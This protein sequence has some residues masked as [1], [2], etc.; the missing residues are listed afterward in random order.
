MKQRGFTL[1][2]VMVALGILGFIVVATHQI[3]Q[4]TLRTNEISEQTIAELEA[5]QTT[6][7][8]MEQD[9]SQITRRVARNEAGDSVE[10]YLLVGRNLLNSQYDGV[11]FI[12]DGWRNPAYLLPRSELQ[13]IAYR[14]IDDKLE[15]VYKVYVDSLDNSEPRSHV[16]IEDVEEF[17]LTFLD[18]KDKWQDQWRDKE[19][20]LA[21]EVE[22][23]LKDMLPLKRKF[24]IPGSGGS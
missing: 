19:L 1:L 2:E 23:K 7:R 14:V 16:L 12:R 8:L 17:K 24:L 22:L 18:K 15:R 10:Q 5:L 3:L 11:A 21:V 13:A 4:T 6:F 20:P 9:F